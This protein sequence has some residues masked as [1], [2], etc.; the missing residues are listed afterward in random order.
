MKIISISECPWLPQYLR[1]GWLSAS[2]SNLQFADFAE[3]I[4]IDRKR[5][6]QREHF[7][8]AKKS[9]EQDLPILESLLAKNT[10]ADA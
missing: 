8:S 6:I 3:M 10:Q 1:P 7:R 5:N 9:P 4:T 2:L